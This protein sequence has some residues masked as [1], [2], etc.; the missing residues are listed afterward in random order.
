MTRNTAKVRSDRTCHYWFLVE[1]ELST[2]SAL[3]QPSDKNAVDIK[4]VSDISLQVYIVIQNINTG[5]PIVKII[6]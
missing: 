6:K 2:S 5:H 3:S 1:M 4:K